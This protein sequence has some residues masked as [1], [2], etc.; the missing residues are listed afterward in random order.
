LAKHA[1]VYEQLVDLLLSQGRVEEA[2]A[3]SEHAR[4]RALLDQL[5]SAGVD[6]R[7]GIPEP[8]RSK[9]LA[10]ETAARTALAE[11]QARTAF[12]V[13]R[14]DLEPDA[15][16][17]RL[18]EAQRELANAAAELRRVGGR[19]EQ[20]AL[21]LVVRR[22]AGGRT[23][24]GVCRS[25]RADRRL[26]VGARAGWSSRREGGTAPLARRLTV[27]LRAASWGSPRGP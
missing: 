27:D 22:R 7:R 10:R 14:D 12:I 5:T 25:G 20:L 15:R 21:A 13:E 6:L 4:G 2:F 3:W 18:A 26:S 19:P 16:R 1:G 23:R 8:A 9:L 24:R 11:W 17:A